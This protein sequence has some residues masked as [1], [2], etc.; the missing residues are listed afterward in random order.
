MIDGI[1]AIYTP[2]GVQWKD[3]VL[4]KNCKYYTPYKECTHPAW[5]VFNDYPV[6]QED[7]FCSKGERREE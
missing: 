4:C 1:I 5:D 7:N 3:L 2:E 6:T